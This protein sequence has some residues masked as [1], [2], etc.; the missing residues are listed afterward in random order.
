M[1]KVKRFRLKIVNF[2]AMK[3]RCMLHGRVFKMFVFV[4]IL[5]L[6]FVKCKAFTVN[7]IMIIIII[8]VLP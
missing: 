5:F 7:Q 1:K 3:N 6:V 4:V 2:T 8:M